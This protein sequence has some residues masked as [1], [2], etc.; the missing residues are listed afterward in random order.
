MA[1]S[2]AFLMV[3]TNAFNYEVLD[4]TAFRLVADM[5]RT[6]DCYSLIYSDL[7]EAIAALDELSRPTMAKVASETRRAQKLL[8]DAL[9][10]RKIFPPC[11]PPTGSCSCAW[12]GA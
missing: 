2:Q 1:K 9:R 10:R 11:R 7:D 8:L 6:C 12:R 3:A 4:E 5:V